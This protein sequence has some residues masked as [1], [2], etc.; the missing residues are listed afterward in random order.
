MRKRNQM[1]IMNRPVGHRRFDRGNI[2]VG[3]LADVQSRPVFIE[4]RCGNVARESGADGEARPHSP[5]IPVE[6]QDELH[7]NGTINGTSEHL[8]KM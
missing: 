7:Y 2:T 5:G 1:K 6:S 4:R 8:Q 3:R